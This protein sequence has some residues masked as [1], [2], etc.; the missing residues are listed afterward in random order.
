MRRVVC[1]DVEVCAVQAAEVQV[2]VLT[3]KN[4]PG[5]KRFRVGNNKKKK[6][7]SHRRD[8]SSVNH[9]EHMS[10]GQGVS[11]RRVAVAPATEYDGGGRG[12]DD[13]QRSK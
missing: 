9:T 1:V 11:S 3:K 2:G 6:D 10:H 7:P 13:L 4:S 12:G 8:E 5:L